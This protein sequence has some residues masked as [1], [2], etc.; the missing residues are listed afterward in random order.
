MKIYALYV[1]NYND[2][3]EHVE[4][5]QAYYSTEEKA[6][7]AAEEYAKGFFRWEEGKLVSHADKFD[8][9][10]IVEIEVDEVKKVGGLK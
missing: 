9:L 2:V 4:G 8:Y 1:S 6:K 7:A 10:Q 5:P 3:N